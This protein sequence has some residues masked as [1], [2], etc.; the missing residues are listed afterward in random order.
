MNNDKKKTREITYQVGM[1]K[2]RIQYDDLGKMTS[3]QSEH[4]LFDHKFMKW[5]EKIMWKETFVFPAKFVFYLMLLL[6]VVS[7]SMTYWLVYR[8][9]N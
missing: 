5:V 6:P 4:S 9:I 7:F 2:G 8:L 1:R 3:H